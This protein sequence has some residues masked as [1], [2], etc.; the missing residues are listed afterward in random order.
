MAKDDII[1][2]KC[3]R[4][5]SRVQGPVNREDCRAGKAIIRCDVCGESIRLAASTPF[6]EGLGV[7]RAIFTSLLPAQIKAAGWKRVLVVCFFSVGAKN[8]G[9]RI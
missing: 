6:R 4:C 1:I 5:G 2:V 8:A 7:Q 9:E 3:P